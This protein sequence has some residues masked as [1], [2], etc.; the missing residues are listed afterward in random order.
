MSSLAVAGFLMIVIFMF[1]L[2][3][4]KISA[5]V[6]LILIPIVFAVILGFGPQ[7]GAMA[8]D[9][10]KKVA[11]TAVMI[12]FAMFYF[13]IMIDTGLFD[14]LIN[15]ILRAVKGDPMKVAVG[16]ALLAGF[17]SLDGDGATTYIIT[18]SA[19]LA[20]HRHLKMDPVILP[21]L[22]IM[23]NGVMNITPWGGPTARVM[24]SLHLEASELFIPLIPGM[25]AGTLWILFVAYRWG[26]AER[27]RLGIVHHL[28][29]AQTAATAAPGDFSAASLEEMG[30]DASLKRPKLFGVNLALTIVLMACLVTEALPLNVLFMV[31][32]AIALLINYPNLKIQS[33]RIS[34]YGTNVLPNISMVLGAGIFTGILSGTKM[35]D[36]MAKTLTNNIPESMGTHLALITGLTSLPFDYFLTNDAFYFG[37][38]PLLAKTAAT[39]GIS[40]AE[41]GRAS[42]VAQGCHL[43]SPLVASTY[44][45]IGLNNITLE[46]LTKKALLPS[47]M[48]SVIMLAT[49]IVLGV[50]PL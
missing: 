31:G 10:I 12:A 29:N 24:A 1:L 44:I 42:L 50:I 6:G 32:S 34:H 4:K 14:P 7:V 43:L 46:D 18:T 25:I 33:E 8:L 45:L 13:M 41:I 19:M 35:I 15:G 2:M 37:I 40:T 47:I 23:Q 38:V 49:A 20:V 36:A 9:G 21:A 22:A 30:S 3:K 17:V 27:K 5:M 11:P 48:T 39:Y 26:I 16:T 28:E